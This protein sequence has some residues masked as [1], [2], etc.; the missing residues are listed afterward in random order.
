MGMAQG[1]SMSFESDSGR[2]PMSIDQL[3]RECDRLR[4]VWSFDMTHEN[5]E[6]AKDA[7]IALR[8][9]RKEEQA[10]AEARIVNLR[11]VVSDWSKRQAEESTVK[12]SRGAALVDPENKK[13]GNG[14]GVKHIRSTITGFSHPEPDKAEAMLT[15][16]N[17]RSSDPLSN[18][19][20]TGKKAALTA[21]DISA[22]FAF[23]TVRVTAVERYVG[24]A[25]TVSAIFDLAFYKH[26][27]DAISHRGIKS[28]AMSVMISQAI[29]GGWND[30]KTDDRPRGIIEACAITAIEDICAPSKF[31][32]L[33]ARRWA[34]IL[35]LPS[36]Y[37]DW[38][39]KWGDRYDSLRRC[40]QEL[41]IA[42]DEQ[43][44][45]RV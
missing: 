27:G 12:I 42:A 16:L 26:T 36:G 3:K 41:D 24:R 31:I 10:R 30:S 17:L 13:P 18:G 23:E 33:S 15:R 32:G 34:A 29:E 45:R 44:K 11:P 39:R 9:A 6:A 2:A 1:Y 37:K 40:L 22:S 38:Q 8:K 5:L 28:A 7:A 43:I 14:T 4:R 20:G 19:G 25:V 35:G 21:N